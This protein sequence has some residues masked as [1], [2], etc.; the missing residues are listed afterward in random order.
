[1]P[2][3][4]IIEAPYPEYTVKPDVP[5]DMRAAL[6]H[7]E[8]F[9]IMRFAD[10]ADRD[11]KLT[12]PAAGM[13]CYLASN[14]RLYRYNGSDW[15]LLIDEDTGPRGVVYT[16]TCSANQSAY[17]GTTETLVLRYTG[18]SLVAG[19]AYAVTLN[20]ACVDCD[21]SDSYGGSKST[22]NV[23]IRYALGST[24]STSS[25]YVGSVRAA[26]FADD[27]NR[28]AG[29]NIVTVVNPASTGSY[30][31]G[32][33]LQAMISGVG[34]R[35]LDTGGLFFSVQDIGPSVANATITPLL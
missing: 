3:T 14:G 25:P 35:L 26:V 20:A 12:A 19:R 30:T 7:V 23:R 28:S 22:A 31:F 34:V 32:V 17:I 16:G 11:A 33:T 15:R 10:A 5:A 6:E 4:S 13:V 1:M 2:V 29:A 24:V 9:T 8:K 18:V 21:T 27:S